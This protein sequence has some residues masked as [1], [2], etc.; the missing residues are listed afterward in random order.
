MKPEQ[1]S[2]LFI[3][4]EIRSELKEKGIE[5]KDTFFFDDLKD[6]L[7]VASRFTWKTI[8]IDQILEKKGVTLIM[9]S[10]MFMKRYYTSKGKIYNLLII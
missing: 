3:R 1:K 4:S 5:V 8:L 10:Q 2:F 6:N 7:Y 9:F